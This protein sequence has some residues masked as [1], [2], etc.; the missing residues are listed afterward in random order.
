MCVLYGLCKTRS[1]YTAC[2]D[3]V[4]NLTD[5]RIRRNFFTFKRIKLSDIVIPGK[6]NKLAYKFTLDDINKYIQGKTFIVKQD[7]GYVHLYYDN[8]YVNNCINNIILFN[9]MTYS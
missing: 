4:Y 7:T 8:Y 6:M 3:K 1:K 9:Y 5:I 2:I